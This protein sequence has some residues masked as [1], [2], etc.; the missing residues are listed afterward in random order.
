MSA[1]SEKTAYGMRGYTDG[2]LWVPSVSEILDVL[3]PMP[4]GWI[5]EEAMNEGTVLHR[6]LFCMSKGQEYKIPHESHSAFPRADA[7]M[8]WIDSN[9]Y[10]IVEAETHRL[11]RAGYGGRPDAL[12]L[13]GK[14]YF[15]SDFKFAESLPKRYEV[16]VELYRRLDFGITKPIYPVL[17]QV[18]KT[19]EVKPK[20]LKPNLQHY[21]AGL[22]AVNIIRWRI[23]NGK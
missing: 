20:Y 21:A 15:V 17:V 22:S 16:Q 13:K 7:A 4:K 10:R 5:D 6:A 9:G 3:A 23:Q 19:G 2:K 14:Q 11:A 8:R 12:L 1:I 18:T